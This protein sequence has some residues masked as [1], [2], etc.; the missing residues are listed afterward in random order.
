[1]LLE[2]YGYRTGVV[3]ELVEAA[4]LLLLVPRL[5]KGVREAFLGARHGQEAHRKGR[6]CP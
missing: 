3:D 6:A 5:D 2:G 4:D 1:L